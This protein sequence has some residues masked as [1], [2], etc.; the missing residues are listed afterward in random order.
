LGAGLI[1]ADTNLIVYLLIEGDQTPQA[2]ACGQRDPVWIAPPIWRNEFINVLSLYVR[3]R[4]LPLDDALRAIAA[5][6]KLVE[7]VVLRGVEDR[8]I[9][10]AAA[11]GMASYDAEFVIAA[12]I[13]DVRVVTADKNLISQAKPRAVSI[14][15]FAAGK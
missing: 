7:T 2:Q 5:A 15:D 10:W 9:R 1:V 4:G 8:I 14:A 12:E 3:S 11:H 6:D 13:A